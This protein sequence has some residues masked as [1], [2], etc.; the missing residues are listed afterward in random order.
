MP[1]LHCCTQAC[2]SCGEQGLLSNSTV[3]A[4]LDA[5]HGVGGCGAQAELPRVMRDL[6][7][8]VIEPM[9]PALAGRFLTTEP[10]GKSQLNLNYCLKA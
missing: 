7:G 3:W 5:E 10:S 4:S 1:G 2:S 9:F 8:P 6:P